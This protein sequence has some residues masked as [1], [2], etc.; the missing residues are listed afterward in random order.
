MK[1]RL[2][3]QE[4]EKSL[5][6]FCLN[7][8]KQNEINVPRAN[9]KILKGMPAILKEIQ[10]N[11]LPNYLLI[12]KLKGKLGYGVFLHPEAKAILKGT[13][14]APYSG[15][16]ILCPQNGES[17]SDYIFALISDLLLTKEEQLK[18]DPTRRYHPRRL[19]SV[20]LDAHKKGNFTRFI[21]HSETPNIEAQFVKIPSNSEGLSPAPFELIYVA[22]KTIYPGEQLLVCYEGEDKS[23]WGALKIKPFPMT[24]KTFLLNSS[25]KIVNR[26]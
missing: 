11:G 18:W 23:Y 1:F 12:K 7:K 14:I 25:C 8:I 9:K 19:Y 3:R 15:E 24:P 21:N 4:V 13:L 10:K 16:V 22:K 26:G 17:N 2:Q 20:D 5:S 6:D